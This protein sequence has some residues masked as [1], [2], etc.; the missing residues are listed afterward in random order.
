LHRS[1]LRAGGPPP[2]EWKNIKKKAAGPRSRKREKEK[3]PHQSPRG[4]EQEARFY[5]RT[6]KKRKGTL[7]VEKGKKGKPPGSPVMACGE[8]ARNAEYPAEGGAI[9]L[10]KKG[11]SLNIGKGKGKVSPKENPAGKRGRHLV[12]GAKRVQ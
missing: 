11:R 10:K 12:R 8:G 3:K 9:V 4:R 2:S 7:F 1:F 5:S 6:G